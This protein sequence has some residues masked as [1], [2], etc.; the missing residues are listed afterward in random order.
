M[1]LLSSSSTG[2]TTTTTPPTL[3]ACEVWCGPRRD[4]IYVPHDLLWHIV[5]DI[6]WLLKWH[7]V[8]LPKSFLK[9]AWC[10][11]QWRMHQKWWDTRY[12]NERIQR[13]EQNGFTVGKYFC[14]LIWEKRQIYF[15]CKPTLLPTL[16]VL[17]PAYMNGRNA[18]LLKALVIFN[19]QRCGI[20]LTKWIE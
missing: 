12:K 17:S 6:L 13:Y 2:D 8:G 5:G 10:S 1:G 4:V 3:H 15:L 9:S 16:C 11:H 20:M 7:T 18:P 14:L 19:A